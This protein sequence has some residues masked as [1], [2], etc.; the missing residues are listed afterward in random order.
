MFDFKKPLR[1]FFHTALVITLLWIISFFIT[2]ISITNEIYHYSYN[3]FH[4]LFYRMHS[5]AKKEEKPRVVFVGLS[6]TREA[7]DEVQFKGQSNKYQYINL[8]IGGFDG[9]AHTL[10]L[11]S[12]LMND[13]N[14]STDYVILGVQS[15]FLRKGS[16]VTLNTG[17]S[18]LMNYTDYKK[19]VSFEEKN[20]Q[21]ELKKKLIY[22][23]AYPLSIY[24]WQTGKLLRL[25]SFKV[26][27]MINWPSKEQVDL[28]SL[29]TFTPALEF[30]YANEVYDK[31]KQ[32]KRI[33]D[34]YENLKK[35]DYQANQESAASLKKTLD[36]LNQI[37]KKKVGIL[38]LPE[39]SSLRNNKNLIPLKT[40]LN[41]FLDE[42]KN[43]ISF[44]VDMS[45][46]IPD[47]MFFDGAHLL[48]DGRKLM[49]KLVS[50]KLPTYLK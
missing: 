12:Q 38:L 23:N 44:V 16:F 33:N 31:T 15:Y 24:S 27:N 9:L 19:F 14:V 17:L 39:H 34:L 20:N 11:L 3:S 5:L 36:N 2:K 8:G 21:E 18:E 7:F 22:N 6:S 47:E 50:D 1:Y 4:A 30:L 46:E 37:S 35:N 42:N 25:L 26:H 28:K 32:E 49:T 40:S 29:T 10:E 45:S 41:S 13:Q 48:K 43:Q